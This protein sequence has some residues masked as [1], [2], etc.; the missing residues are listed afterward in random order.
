[1]R[2]QVIHARHSTAGFSVLE[3]LVVLAIIA[4]IAAMSQPLLRGAPDRL[5]LQTAT[6]DILAAL[7]STRAAAIARNVELTLVL[8]LE[9]KILISPAIRNVSLPK[10][11]QLDV[12]VAALEQS[13]TTHGGI[14]F[15]PDGSST[16]G[17]LVVK[18]GDR[19][20]K[21]CVNWLTGIPRENDGCQKQ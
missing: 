21:V 7:K 10:N 17:D 11:I 19:S 2:G 4:S 12:K 1:M 5:Q 16:G 14:R 15:F 18:L 3:M 9:R 13:T 8:D 6:A 20:A